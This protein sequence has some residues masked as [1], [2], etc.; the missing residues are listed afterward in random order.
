MAQ[1]VVPRVAISRSLAWLTAALSAASFACSS[2]GAPS[3]TGNTAAGQSGSDGGGTVGC[4]GQ[5]DTY[6]ANLTKKGSAGAYTFTLVQSSPAPPAQYTNVW[7]LK[8]TDASGASPGASQLALEPFM[9]LMGH[10]SDQVPTVTANPDGTFEVKDV[11]L[12]MQGLWTVT[13]KV[14]A[15]SDGGLAAPTTLDKAV[16]TFCID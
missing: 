15:P 12:F 4:S 3:G 10:G 9:P 16:Y 5:G 7:T 1:T 14:N 11:Y 6:S 8:V 13:V 2:S